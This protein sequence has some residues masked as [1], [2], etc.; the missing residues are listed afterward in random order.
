MRCW[1]KGDRSAKR[2]WSM[3]SPRDSDWQSPLETCQGEKPGWGWKQQ[4]GRA[5]CHHAVRNSGSL[6]TKQPS[7][8]LYPIS[9]SCAA[10]IH[11]TIVLKTTHPSNLLRHNIFQSHFY[12]IL[13]LYIRLLWTFQCE[14]ASLSVTNSG[15]LKRLDSSELSQLM[16]KLYLGHRLI[17]VS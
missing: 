2:T 1:S 15:T 17:F 3:E 4:A 13:I 5:R 11:E 7:D 12:C 16:A 8:N 6:L 10:Y 14:S 9:A